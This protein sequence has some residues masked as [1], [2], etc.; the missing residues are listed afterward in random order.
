GNSSAQR[1]AHQHVAATSGR[2]ASQAVTRIQVR[3]LALFGEKQRQ[4]GQLETELLKG[5]ARLESFHAREKAVTEPALSPVMLNEA[6][7]AD[8][9]GK[10]LLL[11]ENQL[12]ELVTEYQHSALRDD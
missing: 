4:H 10:Q 1:T 12:Q 2:C 3:L 5:R 6:L 8:T 7:E 9:I 11:R